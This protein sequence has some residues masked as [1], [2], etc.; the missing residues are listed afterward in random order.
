MIRDLKNF[1]QFHIFG[2]LVILVTFISVVLCSSFDS[3]PEEQPDTFPG[4]NENSWYIMVGYSVF[5]FEGIGLSNY[6]NLVL[7]VKSVCAN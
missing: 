1:S 5:V 4:I 6:F 2:D 7:P 3:F